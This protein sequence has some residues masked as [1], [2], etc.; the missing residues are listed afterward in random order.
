MCISLESQERCYGASVHGSKINAINPI[1]RLFLYHFLH[2]MSSWRQESIHNNTNNQQTPPP[3][4][5]SCLPLQ[6]CGFNESMPPEWRAALRICCPRPLLKGL[7]EFNK[8]MQKTI[9][10]YW[11]L[12]FIDVG[13]SAGNNGGRN[14]I[15][16]RRQMPKS[17]NKIVTL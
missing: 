17:S 10:L 16:R 1:L 4:W 13:L 5:W 12:C 8:L 3:W 14:G 2:R 15:N 6:R 11:P 7:V 9:Y